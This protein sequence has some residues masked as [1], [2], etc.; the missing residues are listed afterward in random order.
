MSISRKLILFSIFILM[1]STVYASDSINPDTYKENYSFS[2]ADIIIEPGENYDVDIEDLIESLPED[3]YN[4]LDGLDDFD[5]EQLRLFPNG[6][7]ILIPEV[8]AASVNYDPAKPLPALSGNQA[9]DVVAIARSQLGY[10]ENPGTVYGA[11]WTGV[12]N[13][14]VD[15]TNLAWCAMFSCWCANQAGIG[16]NEAYNKSSAGCTSWFSDIRN[17]STTIGSKYTYDT[18]FSKSPQPGDF[19]FFGSSLSSVGHVAIVESYESSSQKVTIIGGNQNN[20]VTRGTCGYYSGAKYGSQKVLGFGRPQYNKYTTPPTNVS[21]SMDRTVI[22]IGENATFHCVSNGGV[23]YT[24]GIDDVNGNRIYTYD[25]GTSTNQYTMSFDT[26]GYYSCY[27]TAYNDYGLADSGRIFFTVYDHKPER[28]VV[29][30]DHSAIQVGEMVD[31]SMWSDWGNCYTIGIDDENGNRIDTYD[32]GI[33]SNVY[34]RA[35]NQPGNYSCY[36]TA[37]NNCGLVDSERIFFYVYNSKPVSTKVVLSQHAFRIGESVTFKCYGEDSNAY[38]IGIFDSN[39]NRIDTYDT[40][41]YTDEYVRSFDTPGNYSCYITAYNNIGLVDSNWVSFVVYDEKPSFA[42]VNIP[43]STF[44]VGEN[45]TFRMYSDTGNNYTLGVDNSNGERIDTYNT[46]VLTSEYT[47]FEYTRAFQEPGEYS[48]YITTYNDFG[49]ADSERIYFTVYDEKPLFASVKINQRSFYI[50]ETVTFFMS[51]DTGNCYTIGIDDEKGNRIDTYDTGVLN[52]KYSRTFIEK[53]V[54][55]CY[56][57]AYNNI[58]LVDSERI[59]FIVY[60]KKPEYAEVYTERNTYCAGGEVNFFMTSDTGN[61]YTIG[62]DDNHGNRVITYDTGTSSNQYSYTFEQAGEYSAYITAYNEYGLVDS[63]RIY[64]YITDL[65]IDSPDC[66]LPNG[67]IT[68]EE[69]AFQGSNFKTIKCPETLESIGSKAFYNCESLRQ[70]YIPENVQYIAED[71]FEG[72]NFIVIWGIAGSEAELF[73]LEKDIL[74]IE[75]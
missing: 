54:Y 63:N 52:D 9:D 70:I 19:I 53:G 35:F 68:I 48:C 69:E 7:P 47:S 38:T 8:G 36:I 65:T 41:I 22:Q 46:G 33:Y 75:Y 12:T 44:Q 58:G 62:I 32:T 51:S 67:L 72:C 30:L 61:C 40:G 6:I 16:L 11:W 31:F 18:N 10:T 1:S 42:Q 66:V 71:A 50:G 13:W 28:A 60:D 29:T 39:G 20:A 56:I 25:T 14:G 43:K 3:I 15:Y 24:I 21:V 4:Y 27:I 17:N 2:D 5:F 59:Y 49:L 64:I 57:T 23:C 74:F 45:V 73:A 55:S 37:Y 26:S 34:S